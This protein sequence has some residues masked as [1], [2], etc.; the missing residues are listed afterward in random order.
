M[1]TLK[2]PIKLGFLGLVVFF[3]TSCAKDYVCECKKTYTRADG[4][5]ITQNDGNYTYNDIKMD[6]SNRC[7]AQEGQDSDLNGEYVRDCEL[8]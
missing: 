3:T 2:T 7:K 5:T 1:K 8:K 6:A 4:T